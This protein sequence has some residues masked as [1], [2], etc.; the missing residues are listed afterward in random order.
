[1]KPTHRQGQGQG[2]ADGTSKDQVDWEMRPCGMLV[3]RREDGT[4]VGSGTGPII[5][6]NVSYGS[7]H[8]EIFLPA[9]STFGEMKAMLAPKCGLEPKEQRL[10]FRGKEKEDDENLDVAGLKENSKVLLLEDQAS[11]ERKLEKLKRDEEMSKACEA[12]ADV[13]A[14][15]DKLSERV[16][17]LEVAV[18]GGTKVSDKEFEISTELLMRQLLQLDGIEAEGEARVQRKAEALVISKKAGF[19]CRLLEI[20]KSEHGLEQSTEHLS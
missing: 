16:A 3:Q 1:M 7:S 11:K 2:E 4:E 5:R 14:E 8:H 17:A 12:V 10:F 20:G 6:I 18:H 15:V 19:S 9:H 13:R